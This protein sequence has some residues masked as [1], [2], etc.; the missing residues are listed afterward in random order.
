MN[1]TQLI[2]ELAKS[3]MPA[4]VIAGKFEIKPEAV[5]SIAASNGIHLEAKGGRTK[6]IRALILQGLTTDEIMDKV[7]ACRI[8]INQVRY[9]MGEAKKRD[10]PETP[11]EQRY[12]MAL[13]LVQSGMVISEAC[14]SVKLST[15]DYYLQ[16]KAARFN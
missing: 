9:K 3:G 13:H 2:C 8:M 7:D 12:A 6:A 4:C 1:D 16:K 14:K 15:R 10:M 11:I 5:Y